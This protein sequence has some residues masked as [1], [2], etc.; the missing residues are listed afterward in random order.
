MCE[1]TLKLFG[2]S[3]NQASSYLNIISSVTKDL[4]NG[5]ELASLALLWIKNTI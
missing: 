2:F 1:V 3:N 5:L 4:F